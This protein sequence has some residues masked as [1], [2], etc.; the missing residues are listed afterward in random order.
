MTVNDISDKILDDGFGLDISHSEGT[1]ESPSD[2]FVDG[3][4]ALTHYGILG[5]KWG[6]RRTPEQLGHKAASKRKK[7]DRRYEDETDKE[8]QARMV[9]ESNERVTKATHKAQ[10]QLQREQLKSIERQQKLQLKSQQ[11]QRKE[12]QKQQAEQRKTQQEEQRRQQKL[13]KKQKTDSKPAKAKDLTDQEL[14]DAIQRLR[15]EQTYRQ[16]SLQ[17][18]SLPKKT[19][20]KAATIGGGI[21][22]TVGTAVAKNQLTKLG[23]MKAEEYLKKK[24]IDLSKDDGKKNGKGGI[25]EDTIKQI[26]ETLWEEKGGK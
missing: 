6:V 12:Q 21:L 14:K 4:D 19:V 20:I 25:D 18:K 3:S 8:Y 23:N 2:T 13:A 1:S 11:Q 22:L 10:L 17:N 26:F 16:L 5:M 24:G 15:D 7:R 9:R